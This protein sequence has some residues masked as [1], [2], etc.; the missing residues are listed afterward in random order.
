MI[1]N[2]LF[3]F[4]LIASVATTAQKTNQ[5]PYSFFGI[6]E[7]PN[8]VTVEQSA[9][10]GIGVALSHYKYLNLTNPA[11]YA[12][13][14]Y[15][16]YS[17][18]VLNSEL[19]IDDGVKKETSNS[20]S[21]SYFTL[22]LPLGSRAGVSIGIQPVSSV[23]YSLTNL[24]SDTS[25]TITEANIF[26]GEGGVS[27]VYGSFG[28]KLFKNIAVGIEADF[29]FGSIEKSIINQIQNVSLRTKYKEDLS[30]RGGTVTL[31]AQ[32][33][34]ALKNKLELSAGAT[35]K[36]GN[37]FKVTGD[38]YLYSFTFINGNTELARDTISQSRING[39]YKLPLKTTI[40]AGLG[41]FDKWYV[42]LEF[43]SQ[44]AIETEGLLDRSNA[45]YQYGKS[46]RLSLGG[47][48]LPKVNSIS[49]YW[50]R[51][52]YRA[53]IRFEKTGLLVDGSTPYTNF[54]SVDDFGISF[55]LGLPLKQLSSMNLG[56]EFGKRGTITNNLIQENY[57]N[58]RL[59]LSLT[60]TNW[61]Q[62]RKID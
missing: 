6:G 10:G 20:T 14:K 8:P 54:T 32:Y 58:F 28:I 48:Y 44:D 62:K 50:E 51:I 56:F 16:T 40:G 31:G 26:S 24:V 2:L 33:K 18:G 38:D 5:S 15:T 34:K 35:L 7:G 3:V 19:T 22:A 12:D 46:N 29:S 1:R 23:G 41:Q 53:G 43:E 45:G 9:M 61:F 59:S 37:N 27:S 60:D 17:F 36:M 4:L 49:S 52:T 11:A 39:N 47:Y 13:L 42:G 55:G 57:F 30:V 21:L 25:G